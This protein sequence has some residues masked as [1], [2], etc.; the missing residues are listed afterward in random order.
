MIEL[1]FR[2]SHCLLGYHFSR[3]W[4]RGRVTCSLST[5]DPWC[6]L[7]DPLLG[8]TCPT[9]GS[10]AMIEEAMAAPCQALLLL[11]DPM[12]LSCREWWCHWGRVLSDGLGRGGERECLFEKSQL[13]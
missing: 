7:T 3:G 10:G 13:N 11:P 1:K 12:G 6:M 8:C 9:F 2:R 4:V 5:A